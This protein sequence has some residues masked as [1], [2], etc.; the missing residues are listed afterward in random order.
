MRLLTEWPHLARTPNGLLIPPSI[1]VTDFLP[2]SATTVY[3]FAEG[4]IRHSAAR[5]ECWPRLR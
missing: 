2:N 1:R 4:F 3:L 5:L